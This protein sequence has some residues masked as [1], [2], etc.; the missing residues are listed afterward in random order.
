M[1]DDH[2]LGEMGDM[3]LGRVAGRETPQEITLFKSLGLAVEDLA[4]AQH[5]YQQ[6]GG[7]GGWHVR[8]IWRRRVM[9]VT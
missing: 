9:E 6:G 8:R 1:G 5:I 4:A 2:I 3:L 7:A